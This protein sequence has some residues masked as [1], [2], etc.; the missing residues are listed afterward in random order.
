MR[1]YAAGN[2]NALGVQCRERLRR[3]LGEYQD[4][5]GEEAR[6][7]GDA[8]LAK[9]A[10][11]EHRRQRGRGDVDE[12]VPEKNQ[13]DESVR[14]LEQMTRAARAPVS[15]PGEMAEPVPVQGHHA[16]LGSGEKSREDDEDDEGANQKGD[17]NV[18]QTQG[19]LA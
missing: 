19:T 2:A 5:Q 1:T 4:D 16:G 9:Q 10:Q 3:H 11:R 14:A 7:D 12:V 13:A 8:R 15:G 6:R 17:R 18:T